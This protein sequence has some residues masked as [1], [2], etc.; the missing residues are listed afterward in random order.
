[1]HWDGAG[2]ANSMVEGPISNGLCVRLSQ[3]GPVPLDVEFQ[4]GRGEMLALVG[5]SGAG[6]TTVL[7][8]IAGLERVAEGEI[9]SG[10]DIWFSSQLNVLTSPQARAVG[11]V[12]Q[13]YALFPHL[14]GLDNV[15]IAM[16][17][18][19]GAQRES[20]GVSLLSRVHLE[21]AVVHRRPGSL[22]GGERQ[23]VAIARALAR[24]PR[25]LLLD[26]PFS[27]VDR[28]TREHLKRE[29]RSLKETLDIP[30]VLVTHDISDA[31]TLAERISV[32]DRGR[33]VQTGD[34]EELRRSPA[35]RAVAEVLG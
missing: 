18:L 13:E 33:T 6:K 2:G 9:R 12:F 25:V 1:M 26:E 23:R 19:D 28:M 4:V 20:A 24:N 7:R 3:A 32:L 22:S 35:S 17:A 14:S 34:V 16:G 8:A 27:A 5:A 15:T 11:L 21:G 10:S 31:Q 29:L 30:I